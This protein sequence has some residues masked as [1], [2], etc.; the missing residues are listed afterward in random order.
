MKNH[1][2]HATDE[3]ERGD[4]QPSPSADVQCT[5]REVVAMGGGDAGPLHRRPVLLPLPPPAHQQ[6]PLI[7]AGGLPFPLRLFSDSSSE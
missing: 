2:R 1:S 7:A 3:E 5:E 4:H 6:P